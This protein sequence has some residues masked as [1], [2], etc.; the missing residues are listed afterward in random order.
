MTY[1]LRKR[2]GALLGEAGL[3]GRLCKLHPVFDLQVTD[4]LLHFLLGD[5]AFY[6][7]SPQDIWKPH[8]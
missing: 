5:Y 7:Q 2:V 4:N 3:E 1:R 8:A 6:P